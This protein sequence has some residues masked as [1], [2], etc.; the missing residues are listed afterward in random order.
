M[1][2]INLT[3]AQRQAVR[4]LGGT[5]YVGLIDVPRSRNG[6][7]TNVYRTPEGA[8]AELDKATVLGFRRVALV[9]ADGNLTD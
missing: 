6:Y 5:A 9:D 3:T 1:P 2:A 4:C 7:H 8:Q